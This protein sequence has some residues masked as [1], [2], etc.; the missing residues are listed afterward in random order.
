MHNVTIS[1]DDNLLR[2]CRAYARRNHTTLNDLIRRKLTESVRVR[3]DA[4]VDELFANM[5]RAQANSQGTRWTRE[6][7]YGE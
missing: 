5:D 4:W 3:S 1:L 7:L 2:E 6:E